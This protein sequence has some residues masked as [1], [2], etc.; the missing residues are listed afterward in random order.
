PLQR[1]ASLFGT[2]TPAAAQ[3]WNWLGLAY[4]YAGRSQDALRAYQNAI[5]SDF[6][7]FAARYNLGLLLLEHTN[8]T[9]AINELVTY[10]GHQPNDP[11]GWLKLGTAQFRAHLYDQAEKSLQR[12][13]DLNAPAPDCAEA[14]NLIGMCRA[15]K[16]RTQDAIRAFESALA[17]QPNYP[18]ALLNHAIVAQ[19]Q[20]GNRSM[21]LEKYRAYLDVVGGPAS[22]HAVAALVNQLESMMIP[23]SA[24]TSQTAPPVT[25]RIVR[26]DIAQ[27]NAGSA[28]RTARGPSPGA[29]HSATQ[30]VAA[31]HLP[32][33]SFA[34]TNPA[35]TQTREVVAATSVVST[36]VSTASVTRP[37][38]VE[39]PAVV[40]EARP[41]APTP[42]QPPPAQIS[43]VSNIVSTPTNNFVQPHETQI[44]QEADVPIELVKL[45]DEPPAK[46]ATGIQSPENRVPPVLETTS[47]PDLTLTSNPPVA[48]V[49]ADESTR[50]RTAL[51]QPEESSQP[52]RSWIQRLNPVNLFRSRSKPSE[53][54]PERSQL[55]KV[56]PPSVGSSEA[57]S[58]PAPQPLPPA[59][60]APSFPR[61]DYLVPPL[62]TPGN[63]ALAERH[64]AAGFSAQKSGS[65]AQAIRA[66]QE[67]VAADP[68]YFEAHY[69][70][71][72]AA[73]DARNWSVALR[74]YEYALAL[75]PNDYGARLNF[76]LTLEK[77]GY[78]VD[79]A[80]ELETLL[81]LHPNK[82]EAH[83]AAANLYAQVLEDKPRARVHYAR[84]LELDPQHPQAAA[85]R[86]WLIANRQR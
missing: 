32:Q 85:I 39:V 64:Y 20:L 50:V 41:G 72:V 2:N 26:I 9:G 25:T 34:E 30:L 22:S 51:Q 10:T 17:F 80:N 74:A 1:A 49:G 37:T 68:T 14:M 67:A 84:V 66:Y 35:S 61:Y 69:N 73:Y 18:P 53:S 78:P 47:V 62:P 43:V 59:Q 33:P 52:R 7:L 83:F 40:A 86:R 5:M 70:L 65:L 56:S 76:A 71:G 55:A 8:L 16:R 60:S 54:Q 82:V 48:S 28:V 36:V 21:A 19:T 4:H 57:G 3:A 6:N 46:V 12:V 38:V 29:L 58:R 42:V 27:T 13:I 15:L 63:R 75:K 44:R 23:R 79:A 24:P 77:A 81:S 31:G 11:A 45:E